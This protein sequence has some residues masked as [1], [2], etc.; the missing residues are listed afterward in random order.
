[1]Q[2]WGGGAKGTA[3]KGEKATTRAPQGRNSGN[4]NQNVVKREGWGGGVKV[5]DDVWGRGFSSV[6]PSRHH[7]ES[8]SNF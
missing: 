3:E 8:F 2:Q 4:Q 7:L 1:M 5:E 6:Q